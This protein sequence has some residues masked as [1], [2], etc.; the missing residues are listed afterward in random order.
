[1]A[2]LIAVPVSAHPNTTKHDPRHC[3]QVRKVWSP[4]RIRRARPKRSAVEAL[5]DCPNWQ[6]AKHRFYAYRAQLHRDDI[7]RRWSAHWAPDY[8]GPTLKPYLIAALA[9]KAGEVVGADVPGWTMEQVTEGESGRRPGSAGN[10][11]GGTRG[12]GLWAITWPFADG[13]LAAHGWTYEDMWN[14]VRC[15]VVMAE[16]YKAQGIRAWYGVS[17]VTD[18]GRHYRGKLDLRKVLGG[19][20]FKAALAG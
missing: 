11:V 14:P 13:I 6:R 10:D 15:S 1:L 3:S 5:H 16:I 20:S 12:Y 4:E 19:L 8:G 7:N 17:H 18:W 9:E 2:L